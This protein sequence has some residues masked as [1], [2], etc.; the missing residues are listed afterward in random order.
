[1]RVGGAGGRANLGDV[2]PVLEQRRGDAGAVGGC[3]FYCSENDGARGVARDPADR[4]GV[5]GL[6]GRERGG[7]DD[8]AGASVEEAV[9]VGSCVGVDADDVLDGLGDGTH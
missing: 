9:G 4:P 2:E 3:S 7:V 5:A 1:M 8:R 6:R